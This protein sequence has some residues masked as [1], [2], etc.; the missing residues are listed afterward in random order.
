MLLYI[1]PDKQ[2]GDS[3]V[4]RKMRDLV[5]ACE[6]E[7]LLLIVELLPYQLADALREFSAV[8]V[9]TPRVESAPRS[10]RLNALGRR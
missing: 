4:A 8:S 7:G 3:P 10:P 9:R 5:A 1:R 6:A 2:D